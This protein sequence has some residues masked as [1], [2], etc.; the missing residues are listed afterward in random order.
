V[1]DDSVIPALEVR[2]LSGRSLELGS[3]FA[4]QPAVVVFVRHFG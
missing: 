2:D 4:G 1:T 3:L